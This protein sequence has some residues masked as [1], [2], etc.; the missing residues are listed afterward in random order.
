M[1]ERASWSSF[2]TAARQLVPPGQSPPWPI[3]YKSP[4]YY[5][6]HQYGQPDTQQSPHHSAASFTS[7]H[8]PPYTVDLNFD[9]VFTESPTLIRS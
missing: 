9:Y 6:A 2:C 5:A 4:Y 1:K 7:N 3:Q 8:H